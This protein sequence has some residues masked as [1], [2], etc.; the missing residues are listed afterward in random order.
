MWLE[1]LGKMRYNTIPLQT[2][3]I[4]L[5]HFSALKI[6]QDKIDIILLIKSNEYNS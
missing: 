2:I 5:T 1:A 6:M 4:Q 3:L